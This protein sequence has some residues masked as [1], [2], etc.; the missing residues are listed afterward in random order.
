MP[1]PVYPERVSLGAYNDWINGIPANLWWGLSW[2]KEYGDTGNV[3][4]N[5]VSN[6]VCDGKSTGAHYQY[7]AELEL[8]GMTEG[9]VLRVRFY[10]NIPNTSTRA[11]SLPAQIIGSP[12]ANYIHVSCFG[13]LT[14]GWVLKMEL[15]HNSPTD[16]KVTRGN[17]FGFWFV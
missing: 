6:T 10:E 15:W 4:P 9:S 7:H 3:H 14:P 1:D 16:V 13:Y 11:E 5:G 2:D 17:L 12:I 8:S